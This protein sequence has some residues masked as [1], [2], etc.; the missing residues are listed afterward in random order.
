MDALE[1]AGDPPPHPDERRPTPARRRVGS[2][3]VRILLSALVSCAITATLTIAPAVFPLG[4]RSAAFPRQ[5]H[6]LFVTAAC[7]EARRALAPLLDDATFAATP[8]P[9]SARRRWPNK[10]EAPGTCAAGATEACILPAL[11]S[12]VAAAHAAS[13]SSAV[14]LLADT[15]AAFRSAPEGDRRTCALRAARA[16]AAVLVDA[17]CF[18][19]RLQFGS[20]FARPGL[21]AACSTCWNETHARPECRQ[22]GCKHPFTSC[23]VAADA[24]LAMR[25]DRGSSAVDSPAIP[26]LAIGY[27]WRSE[28]QAAAYARAVRTLDFADDV[29]QLAA[30]ARHWCVV[31][32]AVALLSV[33]VKTGFAPWELGW[34]TEA[35]DLAATTEMMRACAAFP[36]QLAEALGAVA[37]S[38][39]PSVARAALDALASPPLVHEASS[40]P[41]VT[42]AAASSASEA[43]YALDALLRGWGGDP[44]ALFTALTA[45]AAGVSPVAVQVVE[46]ALACEATPSAAANGGGGGGATNRMRG[47]LLHA[48]TLGR[49]TTAV[50]AAVDALVRCWGPAA[51]TALMRRVAAAFAPPDV[52][53]AL[54]SVPDAALAAHSATARLLR[55][56]ALLAA[57]DAAAAAATPREPPP[58]GYVL[59]LL[60]VAYGGGRGAPPWGD[61]TALPDPVTEVLGPLVR[62]PGR[63]A[64][65]AVDALVRGWPQHPA[66]LRLLADVALA[67]SRGAPRAF[68]AIVR[69]L[70][71]EHNVD[72]M[73]PVLTDVALASPLG[74]VHSEYQSIAARQAVDALACAPWA[75]PDRALAALTHIALRGS[76]PPAAAAA[77]LHAVVH[78]P[79]AT[80][81]LLDA[82]RGNG[83]A[84]C[85]AMRAL[86]AGPWDRDAAFAALA[87]AARAGVATS[88]AAVRSLAA[89]CAWHG[90]LRDALF[91][92]LAD[93]A[94]TGRGAAACNAVDGLLHHFPNERRTLAALSVRVLAEAAPPLA[95]RHAEGAAGDGNASATAELAL[96]AGGAA[97]ADVDDPNLFACGVSDADA[98]AAA[99]AATQQCGGPGSSGIGGQWSGG[100]CD[101]KDRRGWRRSASVGLYTLARLVADWR[102]GDGGVGDGGL[103]P[104]LR[105]LGATLTP[106]VMHAD[107][108]AVARLAFGVPS[109]SR[110]SRRAHWS[111]AIANAIRER[112]LVEGGLRPS[113][114]AARP[115]DDYACDEERRGGV[116]EL[117]AS[118]FL[119]P[120]VSHDFGI[121]NVRHYE[122]RAAYPFEA[123]AGVARVFN[124]PV[125]GS[126]RQWALLEDWFL[127]H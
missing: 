40:L 7:D 114:S 30:S 26:L 8:T 17:R 19:T 34:R 4:R 124:P 64:A 16:V 13:P 68:R 1:R 37:R 127:K 63:I 87:A 81:L 80:R 92:V 108:P 83:T 121:H 84:A 96:H 94:R 99:H 89:G 59:Q 107:D 12:A 67:G 55:H 25:R 14:A 10:V 48:A 24:A 103:Q 93:V 20:L 111:A 101:V 76:N 105:A 100:Q 73:L 5:R 49:N 118:R 90:S 6:P 98:A 29:A 65:E 11:A 51:L 58:A 110:C 50:R 117:A 54:A 56:L 79:D 78:V 116:A 47:A 95:Q 70:A 66:T 122:G 115:L 126:C 69:E 45:V 106:P 46:D 97:D 71:G 18:N 75:P 3:L 38:A 41:A 91:D 32:P 23:D 113:G 22:P 44:D 21:C 28:E 88:W 125:C 57:G 86:A 119:C 36:A 9:A 123:R 112:R 61:T 53:A 74:A 60:D 62:A 102:R 15:T 31:P 35:G 120:A 82:V 42:A 27:G 77:L 2:T 109:G 52:A 33:S 104:V 72:A 43:A 85:T 39:F